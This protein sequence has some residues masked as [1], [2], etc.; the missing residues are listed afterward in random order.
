MMGLLVRAA[1]M[2]MGGRDVIWLSQRSE[3]GMESTLQERFR[4]RDPVFRATG[5][6]LACC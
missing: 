5:R 2:E 1:E 3:C 4:G 6:S